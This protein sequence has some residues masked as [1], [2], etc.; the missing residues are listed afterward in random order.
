MLLEEDDIETVNTDENSPHVAT[1]KVL[2]SSDDTLRM[3][4]ELLQVREELRK[5]KEDSD[6][7][8]NK[9]KY[10]M[11]DFDNYR[12]QLERQVVT[13]TMENK[14]ELLL[15]FLSIR[16]DYVRAL[17]IA[18]QSKVEVVLEGLEGILKN[19]DRLLKSEG[20]MEIET[21][22]TPFDP[23]VHDAISFANRDD[24]PE[25]AVTKEIR[26]GF[27]LDN[28]VL[29]PSLVEI[30]KKIVKNTINDTEKSEKGTEN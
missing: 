18:K 27:M 14:A 29:R 8:L 5:T 19:F 7:N 26:K 2:V 10:M 23:N 22:G 4:E 12:K 6:S 16:D 11:A 13:K 1:K 20:V 3:K 17:E 15:K 24:L 21:L 28:K 30:S 9:L 25:N